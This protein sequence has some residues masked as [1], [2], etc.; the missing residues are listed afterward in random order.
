MQA[1]PTSLHALLAATLLGLPALSCGALGD[2][3]PEEGVEMEGLDP[4]GQKADAITLRYTQLTRV[5]LPTAK[6][7]VPGKRVFKTAASFKSYFG[8]DAPAIDFTRNS[9]VFYT[10][11]A[12]TPALAAQT[13]WRATVTSI[14]TSTSGL[15]LNVTTRLELPGN[16]AP[17]RTQ[18]FLLAWFPKPPGTQPTATRYY[19]DD[20]TRSCDAGEHRY[21]GVAFTAAEAAGAL[22]AANGASK[23]ALTQAG[24]ASTQAGIITAGRPWASLSLLAARSGIGTATMEALRTLG[25]SYSNTTQYE[26]T[27][28]RAAT[29]AAA[30]NAS[31]AD[32]D[33]WMERV[34]SLVEDATGDVE[35]VVATRMEAFASL[36]SKV[37]RAANALV[38]TRYADEAEAR[39][40]VMAAGRALQ[41]E[42]L[43]DYPRGLLGFVVPR[44]RAQKLALAK[45]G[46][47]HYFEFVLVYTQAWRSAILGSPTWD[48]VRARVLGDLATFEARRE[49]GEGQVGPHATTFYSSVYGLYSEAT[50][51][52]VGKL[53]FVLV[54]ID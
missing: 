6:V 37:L 34:Q 54:E 23:T 44:T 19:K 52:D 30:V 11:G 31:L 43:A 18:P 45:E 4:L 38:G 21:D 16:C 33:T 49:F 1:R 29:V 26:L 35:R 14:R 48:Q 51:D 9:L 25:R 12:A 13:G 5:A 10:P 53:T 20:L 3:A 50:I 22:A 41:A 28:A 36:Q 8:V 32:D 15:T 24:V 40:A 2:V 27:S 7:A 47:A 42:A 39:A 46:I 17:G